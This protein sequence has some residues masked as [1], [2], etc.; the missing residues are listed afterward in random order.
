[1]QESKKTVVF[2][3]SLN[4][5]RY[6]N[7]AV[8]MLVQHGYEVIPLGR[9]QGKIADIEILTDQPEISN[10]HTITMYVGAVRQPEYYNYLLSLKPQRIIFNPGAEN[11]EFARMAI[12]QGIE[13]ENACTLVLLS[14][15]G[16]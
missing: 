5:E 4:P 7:K 11:D 9:K 14:V 16:Y 2:G 12:Q 8:H 15:G 6:A 1:M 10:V 3:A 13:V